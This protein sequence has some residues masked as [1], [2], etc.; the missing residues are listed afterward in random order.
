M[1]IFVYWSSLTQ[2]QLLER[3]TTSMDG[4]QVI[5]K[6]PF[7]KV[8]DELSH[9][10][11]M[12]ISAST[13]LIKPAGC[14]KPP[15]HTVI[16]RKITKQA[17]K[18]VIQCLCSW[19]EKWPD[20]VWEREPTHDSFTLLWTQIYLTYITNLCL[21][22]LVSSLS[23]SLLPHLRLTYSVPRLPSPSASASPLGSSDREVVR[24]LKKKS[25]RAEM[26][27]ARK[28]KKTTRKKKERKVLVVQPGVSAVN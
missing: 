11:W 23:L 18:D 5:V 7:F 25:D 28:G 21:F 10:D 26:E 8:T 24:P 6:L 13:D 4:P 19:E 22:S 2:C 1:F 9:S 14:Y 17:Q 15:W 3:P 16:Q 27:W 12:C 20:A